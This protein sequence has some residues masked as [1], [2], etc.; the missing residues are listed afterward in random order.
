MQAPRV[1]DVFEYQGYIGIFLR[2]GKPWP[3]VDWIVQ[4]HPELDYRGSHPEC[5]W[6]PPE[7]YFH[8]LKF[9]CNV[10]SDFS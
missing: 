3:M 4:V 10:R 9:I 8:K 5:D 2:V 1:G 7:S 6:A